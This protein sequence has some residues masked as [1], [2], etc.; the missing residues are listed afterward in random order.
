MATTGNRPI[1]E[2]GKVP[3]NV[4]VEP[5]VPFGELMP[6]VDV[7]VTNGGYGGIHF[8]LAHGVAVGGRWHERGQ[9]RKLCS[10]RVGRGG[11]PS[12]IEAAHA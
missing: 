4:R 1:G 8:A 11:H 10:R 3:E 2:I 9:N 6:F 7:M 5:F 12:Q